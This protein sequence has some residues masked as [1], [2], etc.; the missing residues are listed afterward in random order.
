MNRFD[1]PGRAEVTPAFNRPIVISILSGKGGVGKSVIAFNLAERAV[2]IGQKVLLVDAD[3]ACGNLHVLGNIDACYGLERFLSDE[4]SLS[5]CAKAVSPGLSMLAG[6]HIARIDAM[7]SVSQIARFAARLRREGAEYDLIII[8]H[9]SGITLAAAI[10]ASASDLN[11]LVLVPELTSIAD[12]YGLYK[13]LYQTN[14]STQCRFLFNRIETDHEAT[15]LWSRLAA[16]V[17]QFL[18]RTP[19]LAGVLTEDQVFRQAVAAQK[20]VSV[21]RPDSPVLNSLERLVRGLVAT[22]VD[23]P[24][25]HQSEEINILTATADTRE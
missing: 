25:N 5:Q 20:P 1:S 4:S 12:C 21:V 24:A 9:S 14:H 17:E 10:I 15:Y 2:A 18:G 7:E 22:E 16:M 13:Y 19:Q 8:D 23:T 11:L 6:C 3:F